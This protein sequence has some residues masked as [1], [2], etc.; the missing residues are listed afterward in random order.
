MI[1]LS[2]ITDNKEEIIYSNI[3]KIKYAYE[4]GSVIINTLYKKMNKG[5]IIHICE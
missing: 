1:S 2:T 3:D 4:N 5:N